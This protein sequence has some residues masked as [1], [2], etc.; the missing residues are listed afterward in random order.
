MH[1]PASSDQELPITETLLSVNF[2]HPETLCP[3]AA[4]ISPRTSGAKTQPPTGS[5]RLGNKGP[6]S[7]WGLALTPVPTEAKD[8]HTRTVSRGYKQK[9]PFDGSTAPTTPLAPR[10]KPRVEMV[11][12]DASVS[13]ASLQPPNSP[14]PHDVR[15]CLLTPKALKS[16]W[17]CCSGKVNPNSNS[18]SA[19][20]G[21]KDP[22]RESRE[23]A[24]SYPVSFQTITK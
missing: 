2:L 23:P 16:L 20:L 6:P 9:S 3:E 4:V 12:A 13:T 19:P 8:G 15:G 17:P 24:E 7:P 5:A 1:K 18:N 22:V 14:T 11:P 21:Q 10:L